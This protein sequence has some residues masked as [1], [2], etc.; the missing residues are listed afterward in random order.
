MKR[1]TDRRTCEYCHKPFL[2]RQD[3]P[4][5]FCSLECSGKAHR[6]TQAPC[7][8]CGMPVR[9]NRNAFC[10]PKCA[11]A[12]R[13]SAHRIT[14][15]CATCGE[16]FTRPKCHESNTMFCSRRCQGLWW[17]ATRSGSTAPRYFPVGTVKQRKAGKFKRRWI[18]VEEPNVWMLY[19][20]FVVLSRGAILGRG[21][22][23]HHRDGDT[24][25]DSKQNLRA[26]SRA[27]HINLHRQQKRPC[28][29]A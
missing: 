15:H 11:G 8:V 28:A 20:H 13:A 9:R 6:K 1:P 29:G 5:R 7:R 22:V 24:L 17:S 4:T 23:V 12:A 19:A 21:G 18:K 2:A 26:M 3:K 10:S 27:D 25:N 14:V 16:V